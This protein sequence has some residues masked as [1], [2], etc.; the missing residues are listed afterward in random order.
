MFLSYIALEVTA[1]QIPSIIR[2]IPKILITISIASNGLK[3]KNKPNKNI[4]ML[5]IVIWDHLSYPLFLRS[6]DCTIFVIESI[7]I[8]TPA[9][10]GINEIN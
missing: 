1:S 2:K 10:K 4:K 3:N 7:I 9:I 8:T 6:N 5:V